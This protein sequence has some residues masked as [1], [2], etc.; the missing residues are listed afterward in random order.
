MHSVPGTELLKGA[1]DCHVHACPHI[2]GRTVTVFEATRQAAAAGMVGIGL[3]DNFSNSAGYAALAMSELNE[4]GVDVFGGPI[5]EPCAGG[6]SAEV[7]EV[8]LD[9]GYGPGTGA[10]FVSLPTHHTRNVARAEGRSPTYI[11]ACFHVP[12]TGALQDTTRRILDLVASRDIVLNTGHVSGPEA[13]RLCHEAK[14]H[15]VT[16]VIVPSDHYQPD[17]IRQI[18]EMGAYAEFAFYCLT[19]ATQVPVTNI[20]REAHA[21]APVA[22]ADAA[23]RIRAATPE[24]AI[25]S[26]DLGIYV[27][28][29]PVEGLRQFLVMIRSAGFSDEEIRTMVARNPIDLFKVGQNLHLGQNLRQASPETSVPTDPA[30]SR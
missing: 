30:L 1:V 21:P 11:E 18:V 13:I 23:K 6:V 22:L 25:L 24:R 4:L 16:R 8:A 27:L 2:N 20:D 7:V 29:P 26:G 17:E 5:L 3:M 19:H 28:P 12:L 9:W 10:R 14:L 15:G